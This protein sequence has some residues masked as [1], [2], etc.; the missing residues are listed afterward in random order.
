MQP[1]RLGRAWCA[2]KCM[3]FARAQQRNFRIIGVITCKEE[4]KVLV[5][6]L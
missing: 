3:R 1:A 2:P 4:K 5:D 6:A